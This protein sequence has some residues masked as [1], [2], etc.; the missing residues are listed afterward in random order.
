MKIDTKKPDM[1]KLKELIDNV[2]KI[3]EDPKDITKYLEELLDG[4]EKL[5]KE[6]DTRIVE[7][8][9]EVNKYKNTAISEMKRIKPK[10]QYLGEIQKK[11]EEIDLLDDNTNQANDNDNNNENDDLE[12]SEEESKLIL[13]MLAR[14]SKAM[15]GYYIDLHNKYKQEFEV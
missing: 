1:S 7:Y 2:D 6:Y 10:P 9:K 3:K 5:S 8:R 4:F 11:I 15:K 12:E 14:A 13:F